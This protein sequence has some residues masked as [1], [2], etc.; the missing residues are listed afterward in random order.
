MEATIYTEIRW[1]LLP[2]LDIY[3][4]Y[5]LVDKMWKSYENQEPDPARTFDP[6][7]ES[8]L[9]ALRKKHLQNFT[10]GRWDIE[11]NDRWQQCILE[12]TEKLN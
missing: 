8:E 5:I 2:D 4:R 12:L 3:D 11:D 1:E 6:W 10:T 7:G 9:V